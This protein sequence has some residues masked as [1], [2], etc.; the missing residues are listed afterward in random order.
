MPVFVHGHSA[1]AEGRGERLRAIAMG[2]KYYLLV[3]PGFGVSTAQVFSHPELKRDTS[4]L[5]LNEVSLVA[6]G[7]DC[8]AVATKLYPELAAIMTDLQSWGQPRMSGTGSTVY[9]EFSDKKAANSAASELKCRYNVRA[10]GGVDR[11][12]LLDMLST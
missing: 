12:P 1:L 7:N 2:R 8:E 9:L 5:D 4:P 10:V 11:S 6:G 3:F